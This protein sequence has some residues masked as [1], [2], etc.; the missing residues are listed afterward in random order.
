MNAII[1]GATKGIGRAIT[2]LLAKNGFNVAVCARTQADLETLKKDIEKHGIQVII[3]AV[4][5]SKKTAVKAFVS[6]IRKEWD[7]VDILVNNAGVFIPC[8]L[9]NE[10]NDDAFEMMM[11]LNLY[12]TYYMTQGI[13]PMMI[14][15]SKGH[16]FNICSIASIMPYGAYAVSKHAM[17]GFSKV[18]REEVK[19]KG[20]RVTSILPGATY[21]AS[22]EG[23][24]LPQERFMKSE[25]IAKSLLDIYTL[26]DQT[27]VEEIILRPQLGDI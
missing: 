26:S 23:T 5:M 14:E 6:K 21:T 22:W 12:S 27:V 2:E 11:N 4:D 10:E 25:D 20:I 3:E 7:S 13:L 16:V 8:E 24:E 17:L 18:L 9:T 15:Q 19:E 1:T